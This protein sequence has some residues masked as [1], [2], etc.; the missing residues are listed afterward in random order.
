MA[1]FTPGSAKYT[2]IAGKTRRTTQT[3]NATGPNASLIVVTDNIG[4]GDYNYVIN[5]VGGSGT[6]DDLIVNGGAEGDQLLLGDVTALSGVVTLRV[7]GG[8]GNDTVVGSQLGDVING[9]GGNDSLLGGGGDDTIDGDFSSLGQDVLRGQGGNDV[10]LVT[11]F[12]GQGDLFDGG[13]GTDTL[14]NIAGQT[15]SFTSA[16]G[17]GDTLV[18]GAGADRLSGAAGIADSFRWADAVAGLGDLVIGFEHNGDQLRPASAG[19]R[20]GGWRRRISPRTPRGPPTRPRARR[21]SSTRPTLACCGGMRMAAAQGL[22]KRWR[23][24]RHGRWSPP[25]ISR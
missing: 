24:S 11:G 19:W 13:S 9:D 21:S 7:N 10:F 6:A 2:A 22:P 15:T 25:R 5:G 18:G 14:R 3:L 4:G 23:S 8:S 16:G 17:G 20:S 12:L 1:R